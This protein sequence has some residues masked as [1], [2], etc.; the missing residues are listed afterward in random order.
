MSEDLALLAIKRLSRQSGYLIPDIRL[1]ERLVFNPK[2]GE[3][4]HYLLQ[5]VFVLR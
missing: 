2:V 4:A 1:N 3:L 5:F